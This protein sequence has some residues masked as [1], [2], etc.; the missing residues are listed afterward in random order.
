M[1]VLLLIIYLIFIGLGISHSL[2]GPAWPSMYESLA[3]PDSWLIIISAILSVCM[4]TASVF[5]GKALKR[6]KTSAI[7]VVCALMMATGIMGF[8]LSKSFAV[9]CICVI[10]L[11]LGGGLI[12]PVIN[13]YIAV[14]FKA[15]HMNMLH[16]LWGVGATMG[17]LIMAS[18]IK[19]YGTWN[20]GYFM[21]GYIQVAIVLTLILTLPLWRKQP[22]TPHQ[23]KESG[24]T[25]F[26][27]LLKL[28]GIYFSLVSFICYCAIEAMIGLWGSSYL[29]FVKGI[30]PE[31]AAQ[32]LSL[33]F[34]GITLGRFVSTFLAIK[35]DSRK[36]IR[37]GCALIASGL[38]IFLLPLGDAAYMAGF[39]L[40]GIGCAP[41]YPCLMHNTPVYFG[42]ESSGS[43]IGLQS[44]S[45]NI[46]G[47]VI[48][49]LFGFF[50]AHI[51]YS[52]F[53]LFLIVLLIGMAASIEAL[54]RIK[55]TQ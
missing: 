31:T 46:G 30:S 27:A 49:P 43:V 44:A 2:L 8:A 23:E 7:V 53:P 17:P 15:S 13:H 45:A 28:R 14:H 51:G 33:Y 11:G 6:F 3:V 22:S 29:V 21:A 38:F 25:N 18:G 10:P 47:A 48:P 1:I 36:M 16:C 55:N 54:G 24:K 5:S 35:I 42:E 34:L 37:L 39:L 9:L 41:I 32:R 40:M 20:A 19:H 52:L 26:K 4:I 12:D 50:A